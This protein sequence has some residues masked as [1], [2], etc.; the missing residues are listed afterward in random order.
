V[1][2]AGRRRLSY[3]GLLPGSAREGF[4]VRTDTYGPNEGDLVYMMFA[5]SCGQN[6]ASSGTLIH[7]KTHIEL[8]DKLLA[9]VF[10]LGGFATKKAAVNTALAE[11]VKLLKRRELLEMRGKIRWEGDLDEM[12][13][14]RRVRR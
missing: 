4:G 8:D 13:M 12:R 7:M 14:D 11:Y 9:E 2:G 3:G 10:E 6:G 1:A 5:G